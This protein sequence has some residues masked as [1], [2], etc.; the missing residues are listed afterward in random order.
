[1]LSDEWE[2]GEREE[3][4]LTT[5]REQCIPFCGWRLRSE[6]LQGV[7]DAIAADQTIAFPKKQEGSRLF[8]WESCWNFP[9]S[10]LFSSPHSTFRSTFNSHQYAILHL[11]RPHSL[12]CPRRCRT[13]QWVVPS[14]LFFSP[15]PSVF[16][17]LFSCL[18]L[19]PPRTSIVVGRRTLQARQWRGWFE[20][21]RWSIS[22]LRS[23]NRCHFS[24]WWR[25]TQRL[26]SWEP[27]QIQVH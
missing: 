11:F 17:A 10:L 27:S 16:S 5:E 15:L 2:T 21:S 23:T 4:R 13:K 25:D 26:A 12:R 1:M 6:T 18:C 20:R 14:F 7:R 3:R 8:L 19:G 24:R 22:N 9:P